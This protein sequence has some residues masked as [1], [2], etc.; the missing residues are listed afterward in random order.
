LSAR[1]CANGAKNLE[2]QGDKPRELRIL[3]AG[4]P[5]TLHL[6]TGPIRLPAEQR[7]WMPRTFLYGTPGR[8]VT[9]LLETYAVPDGGG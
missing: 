9:S 3:R 8:L 5:M 2:R 7:G 4:K 6:P 1:T